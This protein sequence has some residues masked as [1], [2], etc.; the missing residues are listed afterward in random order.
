MCNTAFAVSGKSTRATPAPLQSISF[1]PRSWHALAIDIFGEMQ[2]APSSQRF[3]VVL[4]D[5][6]SK[7]PE[8]VTSSH[9]TSDTAITFFKDT[10]YRHGLPE[11]VISDNGPQFRFTELAA[12]LKAHG[13]QQN[14]T[15]VYNPP[16]NPVER[17]NRVLQ[18]GLAVACTQS[19]PFLPVAKKILANYQSLPHISTGVSPA[20]LFYGRPMRMPLDCM[21]NNATQLVPPE[22]RQRVENAQEH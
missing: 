2:W 10:F 18:E 13:I 4:N 5:L 8:V 22:V 20:R 6:H 14:R 16:A 7:W 1:P 15:A 19:E 3:L 11:V 21:I 9:V 12:F 17:F